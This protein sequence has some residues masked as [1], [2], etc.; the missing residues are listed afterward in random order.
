MNDPKNSGQPKPIP[1][2]LTPEVERKAWE[3]ARNA[4][5]EDQ[6]MLINTIATA[7]A[8]ANEINRKQEEAAVTMKEIGI[9]RESYRRVAFRASILFFG[10]VEFAHSF[11]S[12]TC[13]QC[14]RFPTAT[15]VFYV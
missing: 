3:D 9:A 10:V 8:T 7:K 5:Q 15:S 6:R 13:K 1:P 4:N 11:P 12:E 14:S 2:F